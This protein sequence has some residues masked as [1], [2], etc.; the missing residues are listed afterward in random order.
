M[1][2]VVSCELWVSNR[3]TTNHQRIGKRNHSVLC[4]KC[5]RM[6][7]QRP[8]GLLFA[9]WSNIFWIFELVVQC[10]YGVAKWCSNFPEYFPN[11][12]LSF[13][14]AHY[15]AGGPVFFMFVNKKVCLSTKT[16]T[17]L[18]IIICLFHCWCVF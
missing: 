13:F 9:K 16:P 18:W 11:G 8:I 2:A 5:P 15:M 3:L 10:F 17:Y 4:W 1:E 12:G 7:V 14:C 6:V